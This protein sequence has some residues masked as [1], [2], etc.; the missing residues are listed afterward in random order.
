MGKV[1]NQREMQA[2][3]DH[4]RHVN[5]IVTGFKSA[6]DHDTTIAPAA[7]RNRVLRGMWNFASVRSAMKEQMKVFAGYA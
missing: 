4:H 7:F 2:I 6:V 3:Q 5:S 1:L